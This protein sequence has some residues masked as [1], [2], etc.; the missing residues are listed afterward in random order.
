MPGCLGRDMSNKLNP[1]DWA[2]IELDYRAGIMSLRQIGD[3]HGVTH[4]AITKRA[5]RDQWDRDLAA[6]IRAKADALVSRQAVSSSVSIKPTDTERVVVEANATMQADIILS[7]RKGIQ[8]SRNLTM[9]LFEE[10]EQMT[11]DRELFAKLGE[12][13]DQQD[14]SRMMDAFR[15]AVSHPGRVDSM[16]KL[17][18]TLKTLIAAE[19]EAFGI[20][21]G[22][23][24]Q[25]APIG[26]FKLVP[27]E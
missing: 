20:E 25:S 1:V 19:R 16:K 27:L 18:D 12:I 17:A 7:H 10:L 9:G 2:A 8:R 15:K 3:T 24:D 11:G 5:K 21:S 14:D 26:G 6:K 22:K 23:L 13:M 4:G